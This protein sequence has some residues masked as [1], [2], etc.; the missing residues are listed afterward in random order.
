MQRNTLN[1]T[2]TFECI[3]HIITY[4]LC[5]NHLSIT[6]PVDSSVEYGISIYD[7]LFV[8]CGGDP[9]IWMLNMF[10]WSKIRV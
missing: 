7:S 9:I 5:L 1:E 8:S 3:I 6:T 4:I 2:Y 10:H